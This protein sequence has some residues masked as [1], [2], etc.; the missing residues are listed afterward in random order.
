MHH[1]HLVWAK[2][3]ISTHWLESILI[4]ISNRDLGM[5]VLL[6]L[7]TLIKFPNFLLQVLDLI[8]RSID[9]IKHS[10]R[11]LIDWA[12]CAVN[13]N[14]GSLL[15]HS[16]GVC[17]LMHTV[18]SHLI[19]LWETHL[20]HGIVHLRLSYHHWMCCYH[21]RRIHHWSIHSSHLTHLRPVLL[22]LMV[23][24][25]SFHVHLLLCFAVRRLVVGATSSHCMHS[26]IRLVK[27][28]L[29]LLFIS[30]KSL[31]RLLHTEHIMASVQ[32]LVLDFL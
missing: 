2:R 27:R 4:L 24:V 19:D 13:S 16:H 10:S 3:R 5:L 1:S 25:V 11:I 30:F 32:V 14:R 29:I 9:T 20:G 15:M 18:C 23:L 26:W 21:V 12:W 28:L 31:I 6:Y 7:E 8:L 17:L 22:L